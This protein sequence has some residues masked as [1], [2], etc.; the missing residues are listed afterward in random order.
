MRERRRP[1]APFIVGVARSGT[2]LLRMMLDAHPEM[3]IPPETNFLPELI[4]ICRREDATPEE[5]ADV[6]IAHRRFG[7]FGLD[8][9]VLRERFE[10][11]GVRP[12]AK[13]IRAFYEFYAEGE[14]KPRWGDKTPNYILAMKRIGKVLPEA[15]FIH[16]IRDGR[17]TALSRVDRAVEEP[18]T[19]K[20]LARRWRRRILAARRLGAN[21]PYYMELRYE[22]LVLDTEPTLRRVCEFVKLDFDPAMLAYHERA[23]ERLAELER[24]LPA[25]GGK[26][27]RSAEH[28]V[29]GHQLVTEPPNPNR[30]GRWKEEMDE[31]DKRK[32]ERIAGDVLLLYGYEVGEIGRKRASKTDVM[33]AA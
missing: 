31:A 12:P 22:D 28:R 33:E 17:D 14:G 7:D 15:H 25:T 4:D 29:A 5:V 27:A 20:F 24:D 18:A 13:A 16:L 30:I 2:T 26:T 11:A 3:A 6:I 9:T 8:P 32:F 19:T 1:P 10:A 23:R 21:L